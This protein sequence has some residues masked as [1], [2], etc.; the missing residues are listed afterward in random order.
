LRDEREGAR[1]L[2]AALALGGD[3]LPLEPLVTRAYLLPGPSRLDEAEASA[4]E[5]LALYEAS[6]NTAGRAESLSG[7]AGVLMARHRRDE[8]FRTAC[9]ALVAARRSGDPICVAEALTMKASTAP[10]LDAVLVAGREA[11]EC[12]RALGNV[13]AA[14]LVHNNLAYNAFVFGDWEECQRHVDAGLRIVHATGDELELAWLRGNEGLVA[15]FTGAHDRAELA[16]RREVEYARVHSYDEM[17]LAGLS[18]LAAVFTT[19]DCDAVSA[20]LIG[21]IEALDLGRLDDATAQ[22]LEERFFAPARERIGAVTWGRARSAGARLGRAA[23]IAL[24]L[25]TA[26]EL[27]DRDRALAPR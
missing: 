15:L 21:A 14:T 16:F 17:L 18:G 19:R 7:I 11:I 5:A 24:A 20:R 3:G 12:Y 25:D 2:E 6:G 10:T 26:R 23:A 8:G 13:K 1:W 27:G 4:R 22:R 9:R